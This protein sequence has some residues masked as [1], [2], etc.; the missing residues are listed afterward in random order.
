[1]FTMSKSTRGFISAV[2]V[3]C[4]I[5]NLSGQTVQLTNSTGS[6]FSISQ[7][8]ASP[9]LDKDYLLQPQSP[10][11]ESANSD[12]SQKS[13][14]FMNW[15]S[16]ATRSAE[17]AVKEWVQENPKT[18]AF[19]AAAATIAITYVLQRSFQS[20]SPGAIEP[21]GGRRPINSEYAGRPHPSG[22]KFKPEGF[23]NFS[24]VAKKTVVMDGL[25]GRYG[26]DAAMANRAAGFSQTPAGH[27]WHHVEDG[28]TLQL[29]PQ[30]LHNAVRHTGG[31][32]V[33]RSK[34]E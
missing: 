29:I 24:S 15:L 19:V 5:A 8:D 32:A 18:T 13:G 34:S 31:A 21:V 10:V 3:A 26:T 12:A 9:P 14:G 2:C 4:L 17:K 22:I 1:M 7:L 6:A 30:D 23:P 25:T 16:E 28:K 27:V 33:I 20:D 11:S